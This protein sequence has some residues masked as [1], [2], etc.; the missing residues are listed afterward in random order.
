MEN[1]R[2]YD[3]VINKLSISEIHPLHRAI[4]EEC[5]EHVENSDID[6]NDEHTRM[7]AV[8]SAF[9]ICESALKGT[10]KGVAECVKG[11]SVNLNYRGE[12]FVIKKGTY[13]FS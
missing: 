2:L 11:E 10:I 13:F 9:S 6:P 1:K 8:Q 12:T 7:L 5:C 4:F 3:A